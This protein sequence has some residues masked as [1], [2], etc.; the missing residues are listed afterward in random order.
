M[1]LSAHTL[2]TL[3]SQLGLPATDEDIERFFTENQLG[4]DKLLVD[5]NFWTQG[6]VSFLKE[7]LEQDS[8][9]SELVDYV[10]A[11]LRH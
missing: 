4:H 1:D 10:D 2:N 9:W 5:A 7:A 8:D 3:F 11:R 6:Q